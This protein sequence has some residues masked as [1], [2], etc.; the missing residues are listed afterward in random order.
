MQRLMIQFLLISLFSF[1]VRAMDVVG[2][3]YNDL[4]DP[5]FLYKANGKLH[6][7]VKPK[8]EIPLEMHKFTLSLYSSYEKI[9]SNYMKESFY[10][11][12]YRD[13][14]GQD[15]LFIKEGIQN[16][17]NAA[18]TYNTITGELLHP[19]AFSMIFLKRKFELIQQYNSNKYRQ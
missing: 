3:F 17:R 15:Q 9:K 7:R 11:C 19:T 2:L 10:S 6:M 14:N 8:T 5:V 1:Q 12:T 16:W 4:P 13:N 18:S